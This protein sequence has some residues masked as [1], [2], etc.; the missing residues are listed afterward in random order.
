MCN[1][2][3]LYFYF[4]NFYIYIFVIS[5]YYFFKHGVVNAK[6]ITLYLFMY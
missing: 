2:E 3:Y 4:H 1:I 6:V 5:V